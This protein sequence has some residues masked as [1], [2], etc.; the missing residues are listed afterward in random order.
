MLSPNESSFVYYY[1]TSSIKLQSFLDV[2]VNLSN[3]DKNAEGCVLRM[4]SQLHDPVIHSDSLVRMIDF[5]Y[6]QL[7]ERG[8]EEVAQDIC[9]NEHR[10][11][12]LLCF[13]CY[14]FSE[15]R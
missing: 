10:A 15:R 9:E 13:N 11:V 5:F 2:T 8:G 14:L 6:T 3:E 1:H 4:R 12:L 7:R